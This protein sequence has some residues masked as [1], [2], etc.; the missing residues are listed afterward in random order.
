MK[1][2]SLAHTK[3]IGWMARRGRDGGN[4]RA[5]QGS[6]NCTILIDAASLFVFVIRDTKIDLKIFVCLSLVIKLHL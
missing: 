1:P 4:G 3:Y 5:L 6:S 2:A